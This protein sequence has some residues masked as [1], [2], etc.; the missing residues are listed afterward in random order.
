MIELHRALFGAVFL[1]TFICAIWG[2]ILAVRLKPISPAFR[3]SLRLAEALILVEAIVGV[4]VFISGQRPQQGLH[5]LY[6]A[7]ILLA[8]PAGEAL[9][10]QWWDGRRESFVTAIGCLLAGALAVRAAMTGGLLG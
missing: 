9:G 8:I 3:G 7:V 2:I 10:G 6:G 4:I 5:F 1:Y